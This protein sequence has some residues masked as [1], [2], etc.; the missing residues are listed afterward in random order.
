MRFPGKLNLDLN[1]I[2]S[3]L[4]PFPQLHFLTS[5]ISPLHSLYNYKT[6]RNTVQLF[7]DLVQP[8]NCLIDTDIKHFTQLSAS[9]MIRGDLSL[10]DTEFYAKRVKKKVGFIR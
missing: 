1:E 4:V 9:I 8:Q 7:D 10:A 2:T 6:T 3:N 5:S